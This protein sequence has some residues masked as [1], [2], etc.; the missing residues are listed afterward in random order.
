M[1]PL[2]DFVYDCIA[3]SDP[4]RHGPLTA[5]SILTRA[6]HNGYSASTRQDVIDVL[7]AMAARGTIYGG[8][9]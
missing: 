7:D 6:Q 4:K 9:Y 5:D 2:E 8:W 1:R 3:F